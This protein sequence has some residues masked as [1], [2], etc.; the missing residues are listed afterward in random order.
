MLV[1]MWKHP[2]RPRK[3]ILTRGHSW[4]EARASGAGGHRNQFWGAWKFLTL[5]LPTFVLL[6]TLNTKKKK[7]KLQNRD[8]LNT[9]W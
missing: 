8:Q 2:G 3:Q 7:K 9:C 6:K 4:R 5:F 1:Q